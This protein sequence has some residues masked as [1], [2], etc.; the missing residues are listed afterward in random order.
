MTSTAIT[1][2]IAL[3]PLHPQYLFTLPMTRGNPVTSP[4]PLIRDVGSI[5]NILACIEWTAAAP[6][7]EGGNDERK[8]TWR[9]G[10]TT[11]RRRD[12][13]TTMRGEMS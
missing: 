9:R 12:D 4:S 8:M 3:I 2:D 5:I 7:C 13:M 11:N 10:E 6:P 1:V